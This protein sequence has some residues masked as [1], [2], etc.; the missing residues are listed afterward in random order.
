MIHAFR[1]TM[2]FAADLGVRGAGA[3]FAVVDAP[4]LQAMGIKSTL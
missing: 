1:T 3:W 2:I 4:D